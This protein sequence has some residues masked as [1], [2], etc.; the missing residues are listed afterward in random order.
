M[1][2]I[3]EFD[4]EISILRDRGYI[5]VSYN[6]GDHVIG[7]EWRHKYYGYKI[8]ISKNVVSAKTLYL[9]TYASRKNPNNGQGH[10]FESLDKVLEHLN[11]KIIYDFFGYE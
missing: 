2:S 4:K 5:L 3:I 1:E 7:H 6:T 8:N 11:K 10:V 9:I